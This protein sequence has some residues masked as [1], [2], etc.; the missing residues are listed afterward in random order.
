MRGIHNL[1]DYDVVL[2]VLARGDKPVQ[3]RILEQRLTALYGEADLIAA[4]RQRIIDEAAALEEQ[5]IVECR[6]VTR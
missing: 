1:E 6:A 4:H 2:L 5:L 3:V